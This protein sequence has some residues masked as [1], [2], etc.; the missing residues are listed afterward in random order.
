MFLDPIRIRR[1][2][3]RDEVGELL[4]MIC[5]PTPARSIPVLELVRV[6]GITIAPAFSSQLAARG[7][8]ELSDDRFEN[9]GPAVRRKVRLFGF[10]VHLDIAPHLSGRLTRFRDS[11]QL[12]FE[13][14]RTVAVFRF[15][16]HVELRHLEIDSDRIF[17]DFAGAQ[18]VFIELR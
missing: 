11:F 1:P 4:A 17:V 6:L 12:A 15:L 2:D 3:L 5:G 8:I 10:G 13:P 18:D 16:F 7:A 14:D 9:V